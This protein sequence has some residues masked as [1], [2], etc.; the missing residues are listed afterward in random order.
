MWYCLG[1]GANGRVAARGFPGKR[2]DPI[3]I[4]ELPKEG[5]CPR[6][7]SLDGSSMSGL[8]S[9]GIATTSGVGRDRISILL[10]RCIVEFG[11][12]G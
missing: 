6:Q 2:L 3:I 5:V 4:V 12:E 11:E 10:L 8:A 9:D 1:L 7:V